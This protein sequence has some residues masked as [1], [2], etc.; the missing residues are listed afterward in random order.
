MWYVFIVMPLISVV[1][2]TTQGRFSKKSIRSFS[3][4][5]LYNTVAFLCSALVLA[6]LFFRNVPPIEVF[7]YALLS[8]ICSVSYQSF[9]TLALKNGPVSATVILSSFSIIFTLIAGAIFFEEHWTKYTLIGFAL[10]ALAFYLIPAKRNDKKATLKWLLFV[11]LTFVSNGL[12]GAVML[13]FSKSD[14]GTM[15]SEYV[16]L[17]FL[18]AC[19]IS[20]LLTL[21]NVKIKK[22]PI[23]IKQGLELPIVALIIGSC[24]GLYNVLN[25]VALQHFPSFIV[26][27]V[28]SGA[29]MVLIMVV[30]AL[31]NKEKP[32]IK[33]LI[34]VVCAV[35]AIVLLNL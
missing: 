27:P 9:Y 10:M 32:T 22:D 5:L 7:I 13:F 20:L 34:G 19:I 12:L 30:D 24:L 31:L 33:T 1:K 29:V 17:I 25:V 14:F 18:L 35:V 15:Q 2:V 6:L 28:L 23:T 4:V 26:A 21:F 16:T 8:A 11:V 3:D